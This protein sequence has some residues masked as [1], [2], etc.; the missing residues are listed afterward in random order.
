MEKISVIKINS[1]LE[2]VLASYK[3]IGPLD[4]LTF[5]TGLNLAYIGQNEE[6]YSKGINTR[7]I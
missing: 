1:P 2:A 6:I 7:I 4:L 3:H 5:L